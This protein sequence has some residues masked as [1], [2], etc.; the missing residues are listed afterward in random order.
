[1]NMLTRS[2]S[3]AGLLALAAAP[4]LAGVTVTFSHPEN[5]A[6]V[7]FNAVDRDNILKQ[8]SEHFVALGAKLPAD[9]DLTVEVLDVD[10]AGRLVPSR[11]TAQDIRVLHGGADWPRM[12][13]RYTL[14]SH[15]QV[16]RS[17]ESDMADM[18]YMDKLNRYDSG[19]PV[20]YE[21]AMIDDWFKSTILAKKPS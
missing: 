18:S 20:R 10:L 9:E 6:D 14:A 1:M 21:K 15:G 7:A 11:R 8:L 13:L 16:L 19:D 2:L 12:Q 5:Y 17:G 4:A 3:L